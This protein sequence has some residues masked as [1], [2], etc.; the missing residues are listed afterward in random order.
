MIS[1]IVRLRVARAYAALAAGDARPALNAFAKDGHFV[2]P[3]HHIL[4]ADCQGTTAIASWF[5]RFARLHPRF[6][7][8]DVAVSGPPWNMRCMI[9]FADHIGDDYENEGVQYV[10]MRWGRIVLDRVYLDTQVVAEWADRHADQ[11][12][13]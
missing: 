4:A 1:K 3:G 10:R 6:E 9:R 12:R 13:A 2:F 11:W 8:M 5:Q 7:L